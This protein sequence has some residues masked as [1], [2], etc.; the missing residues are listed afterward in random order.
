M[1]NAFNDTMTIRNISALLLFLF[2]F[3]ACDTVDPKPAD[4]EAPAVIPEAAFAMNFELFEREQPAN[5]G[6]ANFT[7]WLN[8]VV[9]AG[10]AVQITHTITHVPFALTK[11]IQQVPPV[12][13][14]GAY[15]WAADTLV[16]GQLHAIQLKARTFDSYV[17]W[18]MKVTGEVEETGVILDNFV[19]YTARTY[20]NATEGTFQIYFPIETGSQQ[21][22][23]GSYMVTED[24]EHSISFTI[25]RDVEEIG[26]SSAVFSHKDDQVTLDLTGPLGGEHL[27]EW[28]EITGE[29]SLTA[30]DY[31]NGE[32]AC[33][34]ETLRNAECTEIAS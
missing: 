22:M 9:R 18:E 29:G 30:T 10:V 19:L 6:N 5:K 31:N 34:D 12:Y 15:V 32:K 2:V 3:A 28:N 17:D 26:G 25:P 21:V 33:W 16:D 14:E 4:Q 27:I 7:N 23:D 20:T 11:A 8:A 13:N 1:I 24:M